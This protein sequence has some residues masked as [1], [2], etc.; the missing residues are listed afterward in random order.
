MKRILVTVLLLAFSL[1]LVGCTYLTKTTASNKHSANNTID[2]PN[3]AQNNINGYYYLT[4]ET[5]ANLI[6][7]QVP[8]I[9]TANAQAVN[10]CIK[11]QVYNELQNWLPQGEYNLKESAAP[12]VNISARIDPSEYSSL[13]L[14]ISS[15]IS[16]ED[17]DFISLVFEGDY[18]AKSAAHPNDVFFSINVNIQKAER[19]VIADIYTVD[20]DL[21][22][23]FLQ[24][25]NSERISH[26]ELLS[27][28]VFE[29]ED[30]LKGL[31]QEP[32]KGFYSYLTPNHVGISYPVAYALGDHIEAE[33]P[34]GQ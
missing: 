8:V 28:K 1:Q 33:I 22:A 16:F 15:R 24:H 26:S 30:F 12:I 20:D 32:D 9:T 5:V 13:Y 2:T 21:Y 27:L 29:K 31:A 14:H 34:R 6:S 10:A 7:V 23:A 11:E 25:L 4:E 17:K 19:F 18:N 3:Q